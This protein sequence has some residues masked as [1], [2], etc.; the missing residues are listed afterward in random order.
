MDKL[1]LHHKYPPLDF[2][3]AYISKE[4]REQI[5]ETYKEDAKYKKSQTMFSLREFAML[6]FLGSLDYPE[7][8]LL[9][10]NGEVEKFNRDPHLETKERILMKSNLSYF[11]LSFIYGLSHWYLLPILEANP[12]VLYQSIKRDNS[13]VYITLEE[14]AKTLD[15]EAL[16]ALSTDIKNIQ[17]RIKIKLAKG[18]NSIEEEEQEIKELEQLYKNFETLEGHGNSRVKTLEY[19]KKEY[20]KT[21]NN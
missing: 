8:S 2:Y 18:D 6:E 17:L 5:V 4:E 21:K 14:I 15:E 12:D 11:S 3:I 10:D 19:I 9:V 1:K 7:K 16:E 13:K 20:Q